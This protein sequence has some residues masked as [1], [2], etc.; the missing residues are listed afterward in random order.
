MTIMKKTT[1]A[2][3][4]LTMLFTGCGGSDDEEDDHSSANQAALAYLADVKNGP[5]EIKLIQELGADKAID[6]RDKKTGER[7]EIFGSKDATG[8]IVDVQKTYYTDAGGVKTTV[9]NDVDGAKI[10]TRGDTQMIV[11]PQADGRTLVEI[12]DGESGTSLK[13]TLIPPAVAQRSPQLLA[14]TTT[15]VAGPPSSANKI[16]A[17]ISTKNC[18][19]PGDVPGR[20][21]VYFNDSTGTFLSD[22]LATRVADGRYRVEIPNPANEAPL[23]M[24][25]IK[26]SLEALNTALD[27]ACKVD[28]ANPLAA[29]ASCVQI[30][31]ML[32]S[33]G[34]GALPA[35]KIL[36]VCEAGVAALKASC[37]VKTKLPNL[38]VPEAI[39]ASGAQLVKTIEEMVIDAIPDSINPTVSVKLD[40]LSPTSS[41]VTV[42][43]PAASS[44]VDIEFKLDNLVVGE[45]V[46]TP[47]APAAGTDY[48]ASA[49]LRCATNN[50][51]ARMEVIGTDGY[52]DAIVENFTAPTNK[53]LV[54]RVPGADEAGI[55]DTVTLTVRDAAGG[56]TRKQ[57]FL[58]F[59]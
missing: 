25:F 59:Q 32:A 7:Y 51:S 54:L 50:S 58:V 41:G 10:I 20:L 34:I 23:S 53:T 47:N 48:Q 13:T 5:D 24:G 11:T 2:T 19:V 35:A 30:A 28:A 15:S 17:N 45:I 1:A 52:A 6:I 33:T 31:A 44:T 39:D 29:P 18:G 8:L 26:S 12:T 49:A 21:R 46:L 38:P 36:A 9:E 4:M 16:I 42:P 22:Q 57:A 37:M 43:I 27:A 3:L 40:T 56:I 55:R 14:S